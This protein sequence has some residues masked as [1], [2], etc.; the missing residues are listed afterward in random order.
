MFSMGLY[1][2]SDG[3][4]NPKYKFFRF[5]GTKFF[6]QERNELAFNR[7]RCCHLVLCLQLI[8]F[9]LTYLVLH[10]ERLGH[11]SVANVNAA[12]MNKCKNGLSIC[13]RYL[14]KYLLMY[15]IVM[16]ETVKEHIQLSMPLNV[17]LRHQHRR[18]IS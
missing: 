10:I 4:T 8:I 5:L 7:D 11:V 15:L 14:W 3:V 16:I 1:H 2:P 12:L 13:T 17:F 9:Y 6:C 18:R